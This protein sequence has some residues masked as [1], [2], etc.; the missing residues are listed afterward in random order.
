MRTEPFAEE[1][2]SDNAFLGGRLRI[3]QPRAGYRAGVD[4]VLL[5][6]SVPIRAGQSLLDLGCG[7]GIAGLCVAARVPGL[8]LAG[9]EI[10]PAYAALAQRNAVANGVPLE[11]TVGDIAAM[12]PALRARQFDHVIANPPYFDRD[13][14]TAAQDP[15]REQAMGEA[16]PLADWVSAAARRTLSGGSVTMIQRAERLPDLLS[17]MGAYLGSIEILPLIPRR[18]RAARLILIRGRKG[19]R[20]AL[21]LC[22]GWLLHAGQDHGQDG[23]DYTSETSDVLRNAAPLPF[24]C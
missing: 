7:S 19:G 4:P 24:P 10:Q 11:V 15:G 5:A 14:S 18:G 20:A 1:D 2:L 9:L 8:A 23:E 22:D 3:A 12:P 17:A 13:R 16:L 6:A 21:R